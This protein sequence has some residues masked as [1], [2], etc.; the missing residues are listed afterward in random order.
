MIAAFG[1]LQDNGEITF[2]RREHDGEL[3]HTI[4][5]AGLKRIDEANLQYWS[6]IPLTAGLIKVGHLI[7]SAV[8]AGPET[9]IVDK[10]FVV[11]PYDWRTNGVETN[12]IFFD[13]WRETLAALHEDADTALPDV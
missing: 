5:E 12:E 7:N 4:N 11:E 6:R 3:V 10:L 8:G 2:F 9:Q 1:N 13:A